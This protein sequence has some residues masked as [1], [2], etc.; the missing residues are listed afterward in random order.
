MRFNVVLRYIG[1]VLLLNAAFMLISAGIAWLYGTDSSFYPLLLSFLLTAVL[2]LF[3]L[4]F[5]E[6]TDQINAKEGYGIV[7]GAWLI[8]CVVGMFPYLLW[9]GEFGMVNA[10][11]ESVSGYTTT[12]A[13]VLSDVEALPHGLLFWRS[14]THWLGGVGVVMF[15]LVVL[16]ALG[17]TKMTLT[18]VELSSLAKD[19][20]RYRTQRIIQILLVV[21]VGMTALETLMLRIAGMNWFDAVNQAFSTI[22]TGGFS[23]KN[24]SIAWW[25][26]TWIDMII[27][28]FMILSAIHFGLIFATVTGK[29][30]NIFRSEVSRYFIISVLAAAVVTAVSLKLGGIYDTFGQ[31]LRYSVFQ[32][33]AVA[34]TTGFATADT[35]IWPALPIVIL[36]FLTFQCGCAGSTTGGIKC[37][38]TLLAFK[39][40]RAKIRQ[41]QHPNAIIRIRQN[42]V[43]QENTIVQFAMLYIVTYMLLVLVSTIINTICGLDL[44][45]AFSSS[46]ACI[47]N[48]GPGFGAVGSMDNYGE[49]PGVV[50]FSLP[51]FMLFGR[52]EIFGLIQLFLI[53]WWI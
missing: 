51:V 45:T 7:T 27:A 38:R 11:F 10:W 12:G 37:D 33:A 5:V 50:K 25:D 2:G 34:S 13:T 28:L 53:K 52:L 22:S 41:Q 15:A 40:I 19:N 4:I 6:K 48:V 29:H 20:Y 21:Y 42:G 23:T 31:S 43:L 17:R 39:V 30:N 14:S 32:T 47:G 3:P 44:M 36:L 9:G 18:S 26:S 24:T 8:A 35:N 16:P 46:A 49:L 1:M